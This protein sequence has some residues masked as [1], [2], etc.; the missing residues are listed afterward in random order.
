MNIWTEALSSNIIYTYREHYFL[1]F[2]VAGY[3]KAAP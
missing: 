3:F 2:D 1:E